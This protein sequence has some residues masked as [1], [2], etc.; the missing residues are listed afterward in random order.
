MPPIVHTHLLLARKDNYLNSETLARERLLLNIKLKTPWTL[1][2]CQCYLFFFKALLNHTCIVVSL[3]CCMMSILPLQ[4]GRNP[5]NG[6]EETQS[7]LS[8]KYSVFLFPPPPPMLLLRL[9]QSPRRPVSCK[10]RGTC[11]NHHHLPH[12]R[13]SIPSPIFWIQMQRFSI[14]STSKTRKSDMGTKQ[15]Y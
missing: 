15:C 11:D 10:M 1:I 4:G 6:E 5:Q 3:S 7:S 8:P 14:T 13:P 9:L 12:P 2:F